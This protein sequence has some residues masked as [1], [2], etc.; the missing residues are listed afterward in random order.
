MAK[1]TIADLS[2][3]S[4]SNTDVLGQST[5][6]S[7]SA[8]TLDTINQNEL[9]LLARWYGDM[10]GLGTVGGSANAITL[11][12]LSTYQSLTNGLQIAF[13]AG[14]INTA[15]TTLN[16]DALG[17][18]AVRTQGDS[19]L[20]GGEIAA[21]G[22]YHLRYDTTYNGAAGAW[23]LLNPSVPA[24]TYQSYD[25]DLVAVAAT[26][27]SAF[28]GLLYGLTLSNGTDATND[29]NIAAGIAMDG[30]NAKFMNLASGITK[31][32]DAAWAVGTNQGGLD[33]GTI[34]N[35]TYHMWL[36]MRSDTGVVDVLFSASATSP[37]MPPNYDYKRRIGSI[38]RSGGSIKA[39]FQEGDYFY[40]LVQVSDVADNNP[41]TSALTGTLTVPVGIRVLAIVNA[42][43]SDSDTSISAIYFLLTALDQTD[44]TPSVSAYTAG[45]VLTGSGKVTPM[46]QARVR[47]NTSGQVRYRISQSD[48]SVTAIV[49]TIGW[50]DSRGRN[51]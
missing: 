39:F 50:I 40:W 27:V 41:G 45:Q 14:S 5:A 8:N 33:T 19:A 17:A 26:G 10:G 4:A 22:T 3:T 28:S 21:N 37:T 51:A 43:F 2:T 49:Q 1:N 6:G 42:G 29:I 7:A 18:K 36:I 38:V 32:L 13:K 11:T 23:V 44:T 15:A 12:S 25:A 9:A 34:A 47:T 20:V 48:S 24:N 46:L 35:T 30:G 16:L 31:Q